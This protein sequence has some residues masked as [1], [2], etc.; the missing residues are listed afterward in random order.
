MSA[1]ISTSNPNYP[2]FVLPDPRSS[3]FAGE[4]RG[5]QLDSLS[6]EYTIRVNGYVPCLTELYRV[7]HCSLSTF[8]HGRSINLAAANAETCISQD[9]YLMSVRFIGVYIIGVHLIG[10][11]LASVCLIGVRLRAFQLRFCQTCCLEP[12]HPPS[13]YR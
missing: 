6:A 7:Y 9:I 5:T 12:S 1:D 13:I 4:Y 10:V 2:H 11:H 8:H 3:L